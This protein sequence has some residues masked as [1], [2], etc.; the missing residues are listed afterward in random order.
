[1]PPHAPT[2]LRLHR[3]L[4]ALPAVAILVGVP[5][6]N[7]VERYVLGLPFL[8]F[9]IVACVLLTSLVMALVG[10]LDRRADRAEA[11]AARRR[12]ER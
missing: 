10:V 2:R 5:L 8:L 3:A 7:G 6:V 11:D 12:A 9:W 1:M 4:A